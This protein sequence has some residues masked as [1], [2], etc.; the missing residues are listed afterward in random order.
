M[1]GAIVLGAGASRR[2]GAQKLLL[3]FGA[4]T[5][6]GHIVDELLNS[7]IDE[8]FVVVGHDADRIADELASRSVTIVTNPDYAAGMLSSVRCGLQALPERCQ[9][10]LVALGDQPAITAAVVDEMLHAFAKAGKGILVPVYGGQRGHPILFAQR[11]RDEILSRY[12][13]VGLRGLPRAHPDDLC[14]LS[15]STATVLSDMDSPHDYRR[16]LA[17][18]EETT[19]PGAG[20]STRPNTR[21]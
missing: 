4:T 10:V 18:R 7:A 16:A 2:M 9:T 19:P 5:V 11:Y 1:I 13:D 12:D 15:V 3:P 6:I 17:Q 8:V 21:P 14:E 20:G